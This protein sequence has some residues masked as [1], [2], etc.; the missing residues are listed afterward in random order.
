LL[1]EKTNECTNHDIRIFRE[2][3]SVVALFWRHQTLCRRSRLCF[4]SGQKLSGSTRTP[5]SSPQITNAMSSSV[6]SQQRLVTRPRQPFT[7]PS[8]DQGDCWSVHKQQCWENDRHFWQERI[9]VT[10][11]GIENGACQNGIPWSY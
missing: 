10:R 9:S 8:R 2:D 3:I 5:L 7:W 11:D 1:I 4:V 6:S